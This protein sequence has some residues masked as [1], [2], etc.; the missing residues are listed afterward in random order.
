M[1]PAGKGATVDG[2]GEPV[3]GGTVTVVCVGGEGGIGGSARDLI[4]EVARDHGGAVL[5]GSGDTNELVFPGT[6]D[7]VR[8]VLE[9]LGHPGPPVS[10]G[11]HTGDT[12]D[13]A[14]TTASDPVRV[15]ARE[16]CALAHRGQVLLT[17]ST[18]GLLVMARHAGAAT[19]FVGTATLDG[20]GRIEALH[21]LVHPDVSDGFPPLPGASWDALPAPADRFIGRRA[22][23][24]AVCTL[25]ER[26]R[27]VTITGASGS[28]KTRLAIELARAADRPVT[29]IGL[30]SVSDDALVA[31]MVC[32]AVGVTLLS[33][34]DPV[35]RLAEHLRVG[36]ALVVLDDC[37]EVSEGCAG[38][39]GELV[40]RCPDVA[41]L[42]TSRKPIGVDGEAVYRIPTLTRSEASDLFVARARRVRHGYRIDDH[43]PLVELIVDELDGIPLA[44]ELA[45]ARV[46]TLTLADIA[47]GLVDRFGL[48]TGGSR[49]SL[50]RV[51][52]LRAS[53]MWSHDLL[54]ERERR[55]LARCSVF[56]GTFDLDAARAVCAGDGVEADEVAGILQTLAELSLVQA[57]VH[58]GPVRYHL[59][60]IVR[61]FARS[62]LFHRRETDATRDRHLDHYAALARAGGA[63]A[64]VDP[65]TWGPRLRADHH[66]LR[67]ALEHASSSGRPMAVIDLIESMAPVWGARRRDRELYDHLRRSALSDGVAPA[68]RVRA[69]HLA[70][71]LATANG[72]DAIGYRFADAAARFAAGRDEEGDLLT[73]AVVLRGWTGALCGVASDEEIAADV[74]LGEARIDAVDDAR[75]AAWGLTLLA[76]T[77]TTNGSYHRGED[78]FRRAL[79]LAESSGLTQERVHINA[80]SVVCGLAGDPES[81]LDRARTAIQLGGEAG[82]DVF[83]SHAMSVAVMVSEFYGRHDELRPWA[84]EAQRRADRA[85]ALLQLLIAQSA[86]ALT[87][88]RTGDTSRS[89]A[90]AEDAI[91]RS[92]P[93]GGI[94]HSLARLI[95]GVATHRLG[96][97]DE[98]RKYLD[99]AL[100]DTVDPSVPMVSTRAATGLALLDLADGRPDRAVADAGLAVDAAARAF[101]VPGGLDALDVLAAAHA[102]MGAADRAGRL[103]GAVDAGRGRY[104]AVPFLIDATDRATTRAAVVA[105]AGPSSDGLFEDGARMS[106]ADTLASAR[107]A[108]RADGHEA[109]GWASLTPAQ[110]EVV[111]LAVAGMR[112]ADIADSLYVSVNTVKTHLKHAYQR[113]GVHSRAELAAEAARRGR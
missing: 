25:L 59:L 66:E 28:G 97:D 3:R 100:G 19:R 13:V 65:G 2:M 35:A 74:E 91:E 78:L 99:A 47:D 79:V 68:D 23:L 44:I 82:H 113:L 39:I 85:G 88:L 43:D 10:I 14:L 48:L 31:D 5:A 110:L 57:R 17:A 105:A 6:V 84:S 70:A 1:S 61:T 33:A 64:L 49:D 20:S 95:A 12:T 89:L 22:E 51:H 4:D 46:R 71:A 24:D 7:A 52:A 107:R 9:L 32:D 16:V 63:G 109:V 80:W 38:L 37:S 72:D 92:A 55:V 94:V 60:D 103:V 69:L 40:R 111:R 30:A 98:A 75:F 27:V 108:R 87:M 86:E 34:E 73:R 29:W 56:V 45:A 15:G 67:A 62:R 106:L 8:F 42:A 112:N 53:V 18:N 58:D 54:D 36:R 102:A 81:A 41:V 50:T 11:L 104:G 101:D 21:Q 96:R 93:Y 90:L 76:H 77:H 83:V 26:S